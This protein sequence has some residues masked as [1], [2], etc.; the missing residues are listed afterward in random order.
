M[1]F[2]RLIIGDAVVCSLRRR[3]EN[4]RMIARGGALR[5]ILLAALA[6]LLQIPVCA[7][8]QQETTSSSELQQAS[9]LSRLIERWHK[10][11]DPEEKIAALEAALMVVTREALP[12]QWAQTQSDLAIAYRTRIRGDRADNL[13]KAIA[14]SEAA[15]TVFMREALPREWA[16]T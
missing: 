3:S 7:L 9:E 10:T 15:L 16:Q 4:T 1:M 2:L 14:A 13:E 11:N 6:G 12:Q 8:A 5:F